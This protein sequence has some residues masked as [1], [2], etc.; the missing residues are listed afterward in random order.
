M[1]FALSASHIPLSSPSLTLFTP[2]EESE[3]DSVSASL[4]CT[5]DLAMRIPSEAGVLSRTLSVSV[6]R[7]ELSERRAV[8]AA[9]W[10]DKEV[11]VVCVCVSACVWADKEVSVCVCVCVSVYVCLNKVGRRSP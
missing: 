2:G 11:S 9:R 5:H 7:G 3:A 10:A 8:D 1:I 4:P 6:E